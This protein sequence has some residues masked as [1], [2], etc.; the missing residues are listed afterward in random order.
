[1]GNLYVGVDLGKK[2][3]ITVINERKEIVFCNVMPIIP[4]KKPDYDRNEIATFFKNIMGEHKVFC[5]LEK[6]VIIPMKNSAVAI[7]SMA[8]CRGIF[9]GIFATLEIPY[10]VVS[11]KQWQ[12][13]I[14]RGLDRSD[15]K[16][17]G[18][19]YC[20]RAYPNEDFRASERCKN[21]H[22]GK[23]DSLCMALYAW[24]NDNS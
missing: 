9:E 3:G 19:L 13:E 18:I 16:Q 10:Q 22:D 1:M 14:L 23:T 12:E 5:V 8:Y 20:Q 2:G 15:T 17:A 6:N 24:K 21:I 4:G 7:A 11:P